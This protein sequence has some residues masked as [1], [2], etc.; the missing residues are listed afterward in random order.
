MEMDIDDYI[1]EVKFQMTEFDVLQEDSILNWE[2]QFRHW[3]MEHKKDPH[4][5]YKSP[6]DIHIK[7][8]TEDDMEKI[9]AGFY[10]AVKKGKEE[11]Y[12]KQFKLL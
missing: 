2:R 1:E 11:D 9:A 6:E 5:L 8:K 10:R 3:I 7:I 12:W 4:I